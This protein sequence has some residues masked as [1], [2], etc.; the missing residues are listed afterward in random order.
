MK[1]QARYLKYDRDHHIMIDCYYLKDVKTVQ[2]ALDWQYVHGEYG[3]DY[4]LESV[5]LTETGEEINV[6][7]HTGKVS[8][9]VIMDKLD[10]L[11]DKK[12]KI[13]LQLS[14]INREE[15][16]LLK[17]LNESEE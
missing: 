11:D 17:A 16:L 5:R 2:E 13:Y 4:M 8:A 12:A 14:K 1:Y 15:S 3:Y 7:E 9:K 6:W 10:D